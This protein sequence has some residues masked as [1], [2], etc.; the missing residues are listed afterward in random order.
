MIDSASLRPVLSVLV[1]LSV[2][3]EMYLLYSKVVLVVLVG[4]VR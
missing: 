4:L 3:R 2:G 1:S